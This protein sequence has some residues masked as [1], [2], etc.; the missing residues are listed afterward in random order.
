MSVHDEEFLDSI[1]VLALGALPEADARELAAHIATCAECRLAYHELRNAADMVGYG[2]E[3]T[4]SELDELTAARMKNAVM[5]GVRA[6]SNTSLHVDGAAH[7]VSGSRR[8]ATQWLPY[9]AT[10]AAIVFA[11]FSTFD[12]ATLRSQHERDAQHIAALAVQTRRSAADAREAAAQAA[13]EHARVAALKARSREESFELDNAD[14]RLAELFAPDSK[15]Y[16][17]RYGH[18]VTSG[19]HIFFALQHLATPPPGK[20]YQAWT[21]GH[22]LK[23]IAP[24]IT[25]LPRGGGLTIV[26][27]PEAAGRITAVALSVEPVGGSKLPTSKPAFLRPL[28]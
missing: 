16:A 8:F 9:A 22:G 26:E 24:S 7:R 21:V 15:S 6:T 10:A 12:N 3:A 20:V 13:I 1:A 4:A 2:A 23:G 25:F 27:L 18:V 19:G 14:S 17:V 28:S 5:R 11:L